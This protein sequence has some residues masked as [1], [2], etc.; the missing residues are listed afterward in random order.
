MYVCG[1]AVREKDLQSTNIVTKTTESSLDPQQLQHQ[2]LLRGMPSTD[3]P[4]WQSDHGRQ[5]AKK[6]CRSAT[7]DNTKLMSSHVTKPT[8]LHILHVCA[9][10]RAHPPLCVCMCV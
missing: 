2:L 7:T 10:T 1:N 4:C 8:P 3:G 5:C 9:P 6:P